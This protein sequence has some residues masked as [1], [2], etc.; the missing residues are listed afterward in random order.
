P[1]DTEAALTPLSVAV[2][3]LLVLAALGCAWSAA[4]DGRLMRQRLLAVAAAVTVAAG[5]ITV[6]RLMAPD[7]RLPILLLFGGLLLAAVAVIGGAAAPARAAVVSLTAY[8][9]LAIGAVVAAFVTAP[10]AELWTTA[11][12]DPPVNAADTDLFTSVLGLVIGPAYA[13]ALLALG[14]TATAHPE[15]DR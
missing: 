9:L 5:C 10:L 11:A 15:Q 6:L 8:P 4:P 14:W 3:A 2:G 7:A 12:G 1:T 13:L